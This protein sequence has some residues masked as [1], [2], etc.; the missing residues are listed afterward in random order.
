VK[1]IFYFILLCFSLNTVH[2]IAGPVIDRAPDQQDHTTYLQMT[3]INNMMNYFSHT[4]GS[5]SGKMKLP[6]SVVYNPQNTL[7]TQQANALIQ[8]SQ[9]LMMPIHKIPADSL[10]EAPV[11]GVIFLTSGLSDLSTSLCPIVKRNNIF[12]IGSDVSC[13]IDQ[14]CIL[15]VSQEP[16]F[17][18]HFSETNL[19]ALGYIVNPIFRY[20]SVVH[21]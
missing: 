10:L 13:V 19:N 17:D 6:I 15:A 11:N 9:A 8:S 20:M 21:P 3:T 7:S 16:S 12:P 4:S 1:S 18:V 14:C 5:D 2:G